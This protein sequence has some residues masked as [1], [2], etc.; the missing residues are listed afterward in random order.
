MDESAGPLSHIP[1]SDT[2]TWAVLGDG[3]DEELAARGLERRRTI[4]QMRRP[5]PVEPELAAL[6]T[7]VTTRAF[8]PG[9]DDADFLEVNNAAFAWHPEQGGWDE[10]RLRSQLRQEWVDLD[11]FRVHEGPDGR[12][13]GYCWT[14]VHGADEPLV[15]EAGDPPLGEIFA[16]ATHPFRHGTG[17]GTKLVLAGLDHL[18]RQGL[19]IAILHTEEGNEPARAMY[20]RLGFTLHERRGGYR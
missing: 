7:H 2:L 5:L 4:V 15:A 20:E 14:R 12:L 9:H 13:D 10:R 17:L 19:R 1:P 8:R 6:A 18:A 3:T 16:I 11:G